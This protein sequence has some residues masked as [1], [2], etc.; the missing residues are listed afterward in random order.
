MAGLGS[1]PYPGWVEEIKGGYMSRESIAGHAQ[2]EDAQAFL[3]HMTNQVPDEP[4]LKP[5][6]RA[7]RQ[8]GPERSP[9]QKDDEKRRKNDNR[10]RGNRK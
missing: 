6:D 2:D 3:G 4:E 9:N 1:P 7:R 5:D 8:P 10:N